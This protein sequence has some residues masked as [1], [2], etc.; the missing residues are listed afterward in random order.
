MLDAPRYWEDF[1]QGEVFALGTFE[2]TEEDIVAFARQWDPQPFHVD[3]EA[4]AS[5]PFGGLIASGW[6]T[7]C[8]VMRLYVERL[9][10]GA[11]SQGS[12]GVEQ[13]RW[14]KPVRPGTVLSVAAT[15]VE[16]TPSSSRPDRGTVVL[17]WEVTDQDGDVVME[18][19]GR[20]LFGRQPG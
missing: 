5:S 13:V 15:V 7:V 2:M 8:V 10:T 14:R 18:M 19:T 11:A 12:P 16:A 1:R 6:H 3:P 9:L 17:R 4:A 20:G